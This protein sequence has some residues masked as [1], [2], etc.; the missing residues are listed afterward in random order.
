VRGTTTVR[1]AASCNSDEPFENVQFVGRTTGLVYQSGCAVPSEDVYSATPDGRTLQQLTKTPTDEFAPALSPD[2]AHVVYSRQLLATFCKGCPHELVVSPGRQ[3]TTHG[4]D[5][6]APFDDDASFSPDGTQVA[7]ARS[8]ASVPYELYTVPVAGGPVHDLG[9]GGTHPVWGPARIAFL[10]SGKTDYSIRT[11]DPATGA[12]ATVA[13][14]DFRKHDIGALAWA[15]DGRLAYLALD[16]EGGGAS[17]VVVGGTTIALSQT[18]VTGLAWSPDGTRFAFVAQD[19]NGN[20]EV[21]TIGADGRGLRQVTR[22]L[23]VLGDLSW[24]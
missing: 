12:L 8:G 13:K 15:P 11:L 23:G 3:L 16:P 18:G 2:G 6:A 20:G 17:I 1:T 4:F 19:P 9:V 10:Q 5:D 14:V 7:F 24:R 21:F 22:N